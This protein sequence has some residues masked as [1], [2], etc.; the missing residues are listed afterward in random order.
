MLI[1]GLPTRFNTDPNFFDPIMYI[2][3]MITVVV[4]FF[5]CT[6]ISTSNKENKND[7]SKN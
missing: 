1:Y 3:D 2:Y 4:V 7:N 5:S 6:V